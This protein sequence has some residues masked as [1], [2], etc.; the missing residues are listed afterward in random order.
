MDLAIIVTDFAETYAFTSQQEVQ[1]A[2][3]Y[4]EAV[5]IHFVV[6]YTKC[7]HCNQG[8]TESLIFVTD[9]IKHVVNNFVRGNID[10]LHIVRGQ[11]FEQIIQWSHRRSSQYRSKG[12]FADISASERD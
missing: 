4:H 11:Q 8:T 7:P 5:T 2:H 9:D 10:H 6:A 1:S 12:P 3:C